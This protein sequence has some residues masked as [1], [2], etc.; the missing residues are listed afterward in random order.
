MPMTARVFG[1]DATGGCGHGRHAGGRRDEG[2]GS[3]PAVQQNALGAFEEDRLSGRCVAAD[4]GAHLAHHGSEPFGGGGE[5]GEGRIEIH[6][7]GAKE[8][9]ELVVVLFHK[10]ARL[11]EES[12]GLRQKIA[13]QSAALG[14]ILVGGADAA[15]G[16]ADLAAAAGALS[17]P[18]QRPVGGQDEGGSGRQEDTSV[19]LHT[20]ALETVELGDQERRI[21]HHSGGQVADDVL[22]DDPRWHQVEG[23]STVGESHRMSGVVAAVVPHDHRVAGGQQVHHLALA[24]VTPLATNDH[25]RT[26]ASKATSS[27]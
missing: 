24:F 1:R 4:F 5:L 6:R 13:A 12:V 3:P 15:A 14:R 27:P 26:L 9:H 2:I 8:V 7:F 10:C 20:F 11:G 23:E 25:Q 17:G 16:G 22:V 21:D 18:V 19:G